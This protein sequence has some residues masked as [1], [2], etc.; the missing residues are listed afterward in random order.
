MPKWFF[1][2]DFMNYMMDPLSNE[3]EDKTPTVI[4]VEPCTL[5]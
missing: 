2:K 4:D 1:T 5:G 3:G